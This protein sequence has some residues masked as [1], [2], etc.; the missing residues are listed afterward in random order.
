MP[1]EPNSTF[2]A[3]TRGVAAESHD[4]DDVVVPSKETLHH[5]RDKF[6][7]INFIFCHQ[8]DLQPAN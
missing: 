3:D 8:L 2:N 4:A 5:P 7:A 1:R 6:R